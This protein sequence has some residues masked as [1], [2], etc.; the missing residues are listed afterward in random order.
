[1]YPLLDPIIYAFRVPAVQQFLIITTGEF[2]PGSVSRM[3]AKII[4]KDDMPSGLKR[5]NAAPTVSGVIRQLPKAQTL[6]LKPT[7]E[8][9]ISEK[10]EETYW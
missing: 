1:M 4:H 8:T 6:A 7:S 2:C 9:E 3:I 10:E 5:R